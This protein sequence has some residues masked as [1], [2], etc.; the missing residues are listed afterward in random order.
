MKAKGPAR[1]IWK[2]PWIHGTKVCDFGGASY[3]WRGNDKEKVVE[4]YVSGCSVAVDGW[5]NGLKCQWC[6]LQ[7]KVL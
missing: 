1:C 2:S 7:I 5:L 6:H 4:T 3:Q